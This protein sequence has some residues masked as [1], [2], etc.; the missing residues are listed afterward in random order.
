M[1]RLQLYTQ[2]HKPLTRNEQKVYDIL[3]SGEILENRARQARIIKKYLCGKKSRALDYQKDK[4]E[5][6]RIKE[7]FGEKG[8]RSEL[9]EAV[10]Y[11]AIEDNNWMGQC[12]RTFKTI[13]LDDVFNCTDIVL[14]IESDEGEPIRIALDVTTSSRA[15]E[16]D[17]KIEKIKNRLDEGRG[18]TIRYF[19]EN[20][21]EDSEVNPIYNI[22]RI[23]IVLDDENL[24]ILCNKVAPTLKEKP[25]DRSEKGNK[26][27]AISEK[28]KITRNEEEAKIIKEAKLKLSK[29]RLQVFIIEEIIDQIDCQLKRLDKKGIPRVDIRKN[30][31]KANE[32]MQSLLLEK[33]SSSNTEGSEEQIEIK[34]LAGYYE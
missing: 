18:T 34:R 33:K 25:K 9:L 28:I 21:E 1:K 14:D 8:E 16:I 7:Q 6:E 5:L 32:Y 29:D 13:E 30:L 23:I 26:V 2:E 15:E 31:E 24:K 4:A 22:P 19:Q 11:T 17:P 3:V 27:I 12:C 20:D 10:L